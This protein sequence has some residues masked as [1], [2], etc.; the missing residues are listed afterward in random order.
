M[1]G[2]MYYNSNFVNY[3]GYM[4]ASQT[5]DQNMCFGQQQQAI[6]MPGGGMNTMGQYQNV[7]LHQYQQNYSNMNLGPVYGF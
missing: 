7:H 1:G 2:Q 4:A 5:M 3:E 6:M